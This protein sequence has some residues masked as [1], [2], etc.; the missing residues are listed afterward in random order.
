MDFVVYTNIILGY[1]VERL[2]NAEIMQ[3]L[4]ENRQKKRAI[5]NKRLLDVHIMEKYTPHTDLI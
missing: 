5:A 1:F 2:C 4:E 3:L